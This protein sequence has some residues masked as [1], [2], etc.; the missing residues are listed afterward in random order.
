MLG[1]RRATRNALS[2]GTIAVLAVPLAISLLPAATAQ[3]SPDVLPD[4]VADPPRNPRPSEV[5]RLADGQNHLLV[6]FG[7]LIHNAGQ[8]ALEIRG[9]NRVG[10][11]MT[12]TGQRIYRQDS[13]FHDDYSRHPRIEFEDTDGHDHWHLKNAAR[14]SLWNQAGTSEVAPGAKVGFC[15]EDG[16]PV[17][18]FAAPAPAYSGSQIQ[19]CK[20]GQPNASSVFE[21]ISRGWMDVYGANLPFQW[22]DVSDVAPG[23]YR[24]GA[25]MDPDNYVLESSEANNGPTLA[26]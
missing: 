10:G 6:R 5:T 25:Q 26:V 23:S 1:G 16:E 13:T 8:G 17:D 3:A 22:V 14:F 20:E 9:S 24:L 19:R 15:L 18:S 12:V 4:L 21:G 11:V 7:G 2:V